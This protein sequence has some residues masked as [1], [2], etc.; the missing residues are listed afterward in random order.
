MTITKP[1]TREQ[2]HIGYP[3]GGAV[4]KE[5]VREVIQL[6]ANGWYDS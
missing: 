2:A 5:G 6:A 3:N 4:S 1:R